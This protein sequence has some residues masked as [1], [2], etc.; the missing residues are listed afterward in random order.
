MNVFIDNFPP[1]DFKISFIINSYL[2]SVD[3]KMAVVWVY[4]TKKCLKYCNNL[5][6]LIELGTNLGDQWIFIRS[7]VTAGKNINKIGNKRMMY[8]PIYKM[9]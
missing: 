4:T 7:G 6:F 9:L 8:C 2:I 5:Q 3:E 1:K